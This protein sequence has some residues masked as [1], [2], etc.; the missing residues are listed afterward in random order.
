MADDIEQWLGRFGLGEYAKAFSANRIDVDVVTRLTEDDLRDLGLPIGDRRRFQAAIESLSRGKPPTQLTGSPA[1]DAEPQAAQAERRQLSVM[2]CDLVGSTEL[3]SKLDPEDLQDVIRA[4]QRTATQVVREY[5]GFI[6]RCMGDGILVYFGYPHATERDAEAAVKTALGI[7]DALPAL[8][9]ELGRDKTIELAVR[10]GI[11]TGVA[12]VGEIVGEG[13]ARERTVV[14]ETPNLAAR[15]QSLADKNGIVISSVTKDLAGDQFVYE[16]MGARELKGIGGLTKVW[17]VTGELETEETSVSEHIK[18]NTPLVGRHEEIGL[19]LR[20][21][22]SGR[23]GRGNVVL[24]QGEAGIGK[25]RLLEALRDRASGH[26]YTWIAIRSS[27]YR[28]SS[29]LY[30]LIEHFKRVMRWEPG[31]STQ[32]KF[33]KLEHMLRDQPGWPLEESVPLYAAMFSLPLVDTRYSSLNMTPKQQRDATFDVAISGLLDLAARNPVLMVWED[34]HWSDPTSIEL[35]GLLMQQV[36]TAK[37]LV[38]ATHRP[39]FVTP[40]PMRSHITP[41]T[42]N[43]LERGEVEAI[44]T[45]IAG[46]K[47]MPQEVLDHIVAKADGVP[48]YVEELTK[49][50]LESDLLREAGDRFEMNGV[51]ADMHIPE[52]LQASLMARLDR[53][54]T[55]REVAQIG[56]VIGREFDYSML[57][58]L[59]PHDDPVL[60]SGLQQL[61]ENDL[62]YQRGRGQ[63]AHYVFKHALI[64]DAAYQS[65]LKRSRQKYHQLIA[66]M[67][68]ERF[69]ETIVVHPELIAHH[70]TEAGNRELAI[71]YWYRAGQLTARLSAHAETIAHLS[72]ALDLLTAVPENTEMKSMELDL[73][74]AIG[75][76]LIANKGYVSDEVGR[77][78]FRAR[79]LCDELRDTSRLF[80]ILRGLAL[81]HLVRGETR[82]ALKFATEFFDLAQQKNDE[83]AQMFGAYTLGNCLM[84]CGEP[85]AGREHHAQAIEHYDSDKHRSLALVYNVDVGSAA[86][87]FEAICLWQ[88]GYPDQAF[89]KA[90]KALSLAQELGHPFSLGLVQ[91]LR[92]M[93]H[94][95]LGRCAAVSEEAT[96]AIEFAEENGFPSHADWGKPLLGWAM[97]RTGSKREGL[98]LIREAIS[99]VTQAGSQNF[100]SYF[101]SLLAEVLIVNG[102]PDE[103]LTTLRNELALEAEEKYWFP[104]LLRLRGELELKHESMMKQAEASLRE[105][106]QIALDQKA[107]SLELRAAMSLS[108]LRQSQGRTTEA[109][110]LLAP[111]YNWFSEGFQTRDLV[112]ARALLEKLS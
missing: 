14:G 77:V 2:F 1:G 10:V 107:K 80:P 48:L 9:E 82:A 40:W 79:Q 12:V 102:Q 106:R 41:I 71:S 95:V 92:T 42:L 58:A 99:S 109:F 16:D 90:E 36:P 74:V 66:E 55:V 108:R 8:N 87:G 75:P 13:D 33:R 44:V 62:L 76:S 53:V 96:Q 43:R 98:N 103:A 60:Q 100:R 112:E 91:I 70:H 4:Y 25:S 105:A 37:I 45:N 35:L 6:A 56:S 72:K 30:P 101:I 52:T 57:A 59:V 85:A 97:A 81:Y 18:R 104:E 39:E 47:A 24:I 67:L 54:P 5:E 29:T 88:L 49:T 51:L 73:L 15:L 111:V 34:L 20:A 28:T 65:L 26:D 69:P 27:P 46:G 61:V 110:D 19:L 23:Q 93:L 64:Q 68:E 78:G 84:F 94:Q 89:H 31:D 7:V 17:R 50:I 11:S 3:S 83:G 32:L 21:W 22:E 63:R 38:I 86:Q